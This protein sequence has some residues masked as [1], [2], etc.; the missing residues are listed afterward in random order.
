MPQ[1]M[2]NKP[3]WLSSITHRND[4]FAMMVAACLQK[5]FFGGRLLH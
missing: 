1:F 5:R 2:M 3:Q 4:L